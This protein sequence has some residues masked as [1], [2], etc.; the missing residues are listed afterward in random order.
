MKTNKK[1]KEK[2]TMT[3][4]INFKALIKERSAFETKVL[5]ELKPILE[6]CEYV[7]SKGYSRIGLIR[8]WSYD[9]FYEEEIIAELIELGLKVELTNEYLHISW[10]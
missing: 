2:R 8:G 5:A 6:L 1:S 7:A 3:N 10:A 4:T 9:F